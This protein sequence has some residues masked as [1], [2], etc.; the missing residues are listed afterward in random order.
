[1]RPEPPCCKTVSKWLTHHAGRDALAPLTGQD[2]RALRAFVHLVELNAHSD[3]NGQRRALEAMRAT[4]D[5]MQ[6]STRYLAK[7]AIP[8]LMDWPDEERLWR[9][10]GQLSEVAR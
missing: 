2:T 3:A 9:L 6:P 7:I 10:I 8:H 5:A 1:M 4:A